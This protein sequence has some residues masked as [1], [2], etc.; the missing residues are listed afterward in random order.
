MH[1]YSL[2][3]KDLKSMH[4][5]KYVDTFVEL[6]DKRGKSNAKLTGRAPN[7]HHTIPWLEISGNRKHCV[8][9]P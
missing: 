5:E 8:C 9:R 1:T 4:M 6:K 2:E 3:Y 7:H